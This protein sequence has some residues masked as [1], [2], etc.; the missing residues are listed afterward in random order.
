MLAL[1]DFKEKLIIR[2]KKKKKK[3]LYGMI[4]QNES[5]SNNPKIC[6]RYMRVLDNILLNHPTC[7]QIRFK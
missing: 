4:E 5:A 1:R 6:W 2:L 7:L 3:S